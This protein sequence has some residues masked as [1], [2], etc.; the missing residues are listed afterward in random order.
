M[1]DV[2]Q[3][4]A[5]RGVFPVDH[6]RDAP[7]I[8]EHVMHIG[9]AVNE[10]PHVRLGYIWQEFFDFSFET[11]TQLAFEEGRPIQQLPVGCRCKVFD[12][13][14]PSVVPTLAVFVPFSKPIAS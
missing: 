7:F 5:V 8:R 12:S 14:S 3:K 13:F 9:I 10:V 1:G 6:A 4:I 2:I 11:L